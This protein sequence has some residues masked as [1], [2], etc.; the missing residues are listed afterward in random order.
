MR[1]PEVGDKIVITEYYEENGGLS[2]SSAY[3]P[4]E[5]RIVRV[6]YER[7]ELDI[8]TARD[9]RGKL[10]NLFLWNLPKSVTWRY[11]VRAGDK[12]LVSAVD[13]REI[14]DTV[15][16]ALEDERLGFVLETGGDPEYGLDL[17]CL[18]DTR[19]SAITADEWEFY[20]GEDEEEYTPQS[21]ADYNT[22]SGG[23][24]TLKDYTGVGF[25][26]EE[27][28][29]KSSHEKALEQ[30]TAESLSFKESE[31]DVVVAPDNVNHPSHYNYGDIEVIDFIEQVT[32][33]YEDGFDAYIVGN[34]LK[35]LSR[36]PMKNGLE[37]V[38]K[39]VWYLNRLIERKENE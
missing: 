15:V 5:A 37:D 12:L 31:E 4:V 20:Y 28:A 32:E 3:P 23:G 18:S 22:S 16:T 9:S 29:F 10:F 6:S 36:S 30:L 21:F 11:A 17:I 1:T 14:E 24:K 25:T 2:V 26:K 39:S 19:G 38:K 35:Y 7:G 33:A 34:A 13:G 27:L 8:L